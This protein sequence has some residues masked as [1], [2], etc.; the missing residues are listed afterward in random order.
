MNPALWILAVVFALFAAVVIIAALVLMVNALSDFLKEWRERA[1]S[2][3]NPALLEE[4]I[5]IRPNGLVELG[6]IVPKSEWR[7]WPFPHIRTTF[8]ARANAT[9]SLDNLAALIRPEN[10]LNAETIEN[11]MLL[12][13]DPAT[14]GAKKIATKIFESLHGREW[15]RNEI[16]RLTAPE[17]A[18]EPLAKAAHLLQTTAHA[19]LRRNRQTLALHARE[20]I[21]Y[22]LQSLFEKMLE[23]QLRTL[24]TDKLKD[25][26]C[27]G[28]GA[29]PPG[30][31]FYKSYR[32]MRIFVIQE[33]P[34][35]HN[36][37]FTKEFF[38][39][40][41]TTQP[42]EQALF[43]LAFPYVIFVIVMLVDSDGNSNYGHTMHAFVTPRP[44]QT[45][46]DQLFRFPLSNV[47][48]EGKV[49]L[50]NSN[51]QHDHPGATAV[52]MLAHFWDSAFNG[53]FYSYAL[54]NYFNAG[55]KFK[56]VREWEVKSAENPRFMTD[57][58]LLT[59][60]YPGSS[61]AQEVI[62]GALEGKYKKLSTQ[63]ALATTPVIDATAKLWEELADD[64]CLRLEDELPANQYGEITVD[65]LAEYL[66]LA[67]NKLADT[68]AAN[69]D[70]APDEKHP[71]AKDD[72]ASGTALS[73]N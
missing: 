59:H 21:K 44:L 68:I 53:D 39:K 46:K 18:Q 30:T 9:I 13:R 60:H 48:F 22:E 42:D 47:Y 40:T 34:A 1:A 31:I 17:H 7:L 62:N 58:E 19:Q 61:T 20:K 2:N 51:W 45:L 25:F 10:P 6:N 23:P 55:P 37:R 28:R 38:E 50:G 54:P 4:T 73:E 56:D 64:F 3:A 16:K 66:A 72:P 57:A 32:D 71:A 8:A 52:A 36:I 33:K 24:L 43:R 70:R 29:L 14:E 35:C 65:T 26:E 15:I 27:D 41:G 67:E 63:V 11:H 5:S 12:R 69:L 49:C